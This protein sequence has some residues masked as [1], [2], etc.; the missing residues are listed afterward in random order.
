ML[1]APALRAVMASLQPHSVPPSA[2]RLRSPLVGRRPEISMLEAALGE[3]L[4]RRAPHA[5]TVMGAPGVG[6]TRL[7]R[8]FLAD[9]R[10]QDDSVNVYTGQTREGGPAFGAIRSLLRARLGPPE[11][12]KGEALEAQF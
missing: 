3:T 6:K 12:L 2:P 10:A 9:V 11:A 1:L 7:V 5:I 8:E 4:E